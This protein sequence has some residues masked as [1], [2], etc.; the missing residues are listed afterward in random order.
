MSKPSF[1]LRIAA[2]LSIT[3][4]QAAIR[5]RTTFTDDDPERGDVPRGS[6]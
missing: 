6:L 1:F 5:L 3:M 2:V 4:A